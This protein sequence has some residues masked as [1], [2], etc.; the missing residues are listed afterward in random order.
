MWWKAALFL[1]MPVLRAQ[2]VEGTV[3][4]R[5]SGQAAGVSVTLNGAKT[6]TVFTDGSGEYR[7]DGVEP[8][9]YTTVVGARGYSLD[10]ESASA[11]RAR[12]GVVRRSLLLVPLLTVS[13]RVLYPDGKPAPRTPVYLLYG[14]GSLQGRTDEQ[15][16]FTISTTIRSRRY[17]LMAGA[18]PNPVP[19]EGEAWA[20][21]YYSNVLTRAEAVP[22]A[23]STGAEASGYEIRLRSLPVFRMRGFVFDDLGK[24]AAGV[25]VRLVGTDWARTEE[26]RAITDGEGAF[27]FPVV[28]SGDWN[29]LATLKRDGAELRASQPVTVARR[30]A[31]RVQ[32]RLARPFALSGLVERG[33]PPDASGKRK[34]SA[35][36]LVP[37]DARSAMNKV[38]FH[39]QDGRVAI[40]D[41]YPGRYRIHPLGYVSGYYLASVLLGEREVLGQYVDLSESSPPFRIRYE[42]NAP[43]V[44]G[45]IEK[46]EG[47]FVTLI[48]TDDAFLNDQFV[49]IQ[50]VGKDG[51]FEV[52]TV[53]PGEYYA[54]AFDR[55]DDAALYDPAFVAGIAP[56]AVR[57]TV[58]KGE[59]VTVDLKI[60]PWPE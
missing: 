40:K 24:A 22:I 13:G 16:R 11:F 15:G 28:R 57:V 18:P 52:G 12:E 44:T 32:V 41:V 37:E 51:R 30:D 1:A 8:G 9:Q 31:D 29:V 54:F 47:A 39:E 43:R 17:T 19:V 55:F 46:G 49:R 2:V 21:T 59:T 50:A 35:V 42:G 36:A 5:G 48:P 4:I 6:Y 38:S 34:I 3:S 26:G 23:L 60:L 14:I 56:R 33:D 25:P 45:R 20:P 27:E 58:V 53:R 7:F 10:V